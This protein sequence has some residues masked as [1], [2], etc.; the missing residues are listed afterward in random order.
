M[1]R[2]KETS[3][4]LSDMTHKFG[5]GLST[6]DAEN[7]FQLVGDQAF[8]ELADLSRRFDRVTPKEIRRWLWEIRYNPV[9]E[10][11]DVLVMV[12]R[13]DPTG[14][15][16]RIGQVGSPDADTAIIFTEDQ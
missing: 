8:V 3:R 9:W 16:G 7:G 12:E 15:V 13:E 14:W 5:I 6:P 1:S 4:L 11:P 10:D 2:W